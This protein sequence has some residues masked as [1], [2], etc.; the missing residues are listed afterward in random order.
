MRCYKKHNVRLSPSTL[1]TKSKEQ[2]DVAGEGGSGTDAIFDPR[3]S[4]SWLI[5]CNTCH[6]LSLG[7][8]ES[9]RRSN[10]RAA[11]PYEF[12]AAAGSEVPDQRLMERMCQRDS[13]RIR[14]RN[15]CLKR[16]FY[17]LV[18][19]HWDLVIFLPQQRTKHTHSPSSSWRT[20]RLQCDRIRLRPTSRVATCQLPISWR[21]TVATP[22]PIF[23]SPLTL[24]AKK[25]R[26]ISPG[27]SLGWKADFEEPR[28]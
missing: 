6:N 5:S 20:A 21:D 22:S 28:I 14:T 4:S 1:A 26:L 17:R 18:R 16:S 3:L 24:E 19:L 12:D 15:E 23:Q 25:L 10:T 8:V 2:S 27:K 11:N 13:G 7:G 9:S